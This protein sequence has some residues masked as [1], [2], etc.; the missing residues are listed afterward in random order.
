VGQVRV[1]GFLKNI[2]P[3]KLGSLQYFLLEAAMHRE[4]DEKV[5]HARLFAQILGAGFKIK[6]EGVDLLLEEYAEEVHQMRYNS[7]YQTAIARTIREKARQSEEDLRI[8]EKVKQ[9]TVED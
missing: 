6:S 3:P 4:R 8:L 1:F 7:K 9:M 2:P 5:A